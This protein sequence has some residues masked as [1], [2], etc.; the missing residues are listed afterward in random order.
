MDSCFTLRI[1]GGKI[2]LRKRL[3]PV[4]VLWWMIVTCSDLFQRRQASILKTYISVFSAGKS[5]GTFKGHCKT[6]K[7]PTSRKIQRHFVKAEQLYWNGV[8]W[9]LAFVVFLHDF[10]QRPRLGFAALQKMLSSKTQVKMGKQSG[11]HACVGKSLK[12]RCLNNRAPY[13][14]CKWFI[15]V[16][17]NLILLGR[18]YWVHLWLSNPGFQLI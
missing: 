10:D 12:T 3:F 11:D 13:R 16:L 17:S 9:L 8:F 7:T 6:N 18:C 15:E 4:C 14:H 5:L 1:L 2:H